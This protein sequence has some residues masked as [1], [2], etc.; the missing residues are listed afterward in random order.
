MHPFL[1]C[2][3][4]E[5]FVSQQIIVTGWLPLEIH[6]VDDTIELYV[7]DEYKKPIYSKF[8]Y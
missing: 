3:P 1:Q 2:M 6:E 5:S 8:K 7:K 4:L